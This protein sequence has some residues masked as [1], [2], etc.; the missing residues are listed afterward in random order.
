MK[1]L[2]SLGLNVGKCVLLIPT[3]VELLKGIRTK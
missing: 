1:F 3:S 2:A